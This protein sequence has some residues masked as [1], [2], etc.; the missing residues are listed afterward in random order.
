MYIWGDVCLSLYFHHS[1]QLSFFF[2]LSFHPTLLPLYFSLLS[3]HF[4][5]S[6]CGCLSSFLQ[7]IKVCFLSNSKLKE[8]WSRVTD[9]PTGCHICCLSISTGKQV[10]DQ[11]S[12]LDQKQPLWWL[13]QPDWGFITRMIRAGPWENR[14]T[15][16]QISTWKDIWD[17]LTKLKPRN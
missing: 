1:L 8:D 10:S 2:S 13:Q 9:Q 15:S 4:S 6:N 11:H 14:P 5:D 7:T 12:D 16:S 3:P 17:F